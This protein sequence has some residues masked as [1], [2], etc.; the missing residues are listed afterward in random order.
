MYI[1]RKQWEEHYH[2]SEE[3]R[4]DLHERKEFVDI[5]EK[6]T[7]GFLDLNNLEK[8]GWFERIKEDFRNIDEYAESC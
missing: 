7:K 6:F 1:L 3:E 2:L 8:S 4:R 5:L